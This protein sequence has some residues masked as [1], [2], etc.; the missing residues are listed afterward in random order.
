MLQQRFAIAVNKPSLAKR[1][2]DMKEQTRYMKN[3][4]SALGSALDEVQ[5]L[6]GELRRHKSDTMGANVFDSPMMPLSE[7]NSHLVVEISCATHTAATK[8]D[9]IKTSMS[10][11]NKLCSNLAAQLRVFAKALVQRDKKLAEKI[12][13]NKELSLKVR[14]LETSLRK[15][16]SELRTCK[17]RLADSQRGLL[18]R[19]R[20]IIKR[21][22]EISN[23][24]RNVWSLTRRLQQV[25]S[26]LDQSKQSNGL[27]GRF[28]NQLKLEP[29]ADA[30]GTNR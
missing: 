5:A 24:D 12:K 8:L 25:E 4:R 3:C 1:L 2:D 7:K 20:E 27:C 17:A 23:L 26:H 13:L 16:N 28:E 10:K 6:K 9:R 21:G 11:K 29:N 19:D 18:S 30:V 15:S 22:R 14:H